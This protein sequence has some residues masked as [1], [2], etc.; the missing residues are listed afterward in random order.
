MKFPKI[1]SLFC[2]TDINGDGSLDYA[3][4]KGNIM[5]WVS[6]VSL[7]GIVIALFKGVKIDNTSLDS[8]VSI[9]K[10]VFTTTFIYAGFKR[11]SNAWTEVEI[12]KEGLKT[13]N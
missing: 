12:T 11:G 13:K 5:C 2:D 7:I 9:L 3:L 4:S 6:F 10:F 1:A 8:I